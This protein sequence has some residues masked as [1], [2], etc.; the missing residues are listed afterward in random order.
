MFEIDLLQGTGRPAQPQPMRVLMWCGL[1]TVLVALGLCL[2][3]ATWSIRND[4]R[5]QKQSL[6]QLTR[7]ISSMDQV[8]SFVTR[9]DAEQKILAPKLQVL[10]QVLPGQIQWSPIL[11]GIARQAPDGLVLSD[12]TARQN[13]TPQKTQ[14]LQSSYTLT[15]SAITAS[16]PYLVESF[17]QTLS[18]SNWAPNYHKNIRIATQGQRKIQNQICMHFTIECILTPLSQES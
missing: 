3:Q 6:A 7:Q 15:L 9:L 4:I 16:D 10:G 5:I 13:I 11:E 2:A 12:F 14:G 8:T 17:M 18:Q 1:Y